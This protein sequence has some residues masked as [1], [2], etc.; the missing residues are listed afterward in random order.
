MEI[1]NV[2]PII[3]GE[4]VRF[5]KKITL[6]HKDIEINRNYTVKQVKT[7][8]F[9]F[10]KQGIRKI[11]QLVELKEL[12]GL[13]F[14]ADWI[15]ID[16]REIPIPGIKLVSFKEYKKLRG[17]LAKEEHER[18][19]QISSSQEQYRE[20]FRVAGEV[21]FG[22]PPHPEMELLARVCMLK[23]KLSSLDKMCE[24][25]LLQGKK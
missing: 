8:T 7:Q 3:L 17:Q 1:T 13:W 20:A 12:P 10:R 21:G 18:L 4:K 9:N 11:N 14:S 24:M 5:R 23:S 6:I 25:L 16:S 22:Y 2:K 15:E 19:N